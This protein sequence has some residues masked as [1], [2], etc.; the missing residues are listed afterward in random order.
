MYYVEYV[1]RLSKKCFSEHPMHTADNEYLRYIFLDGGRPMLQEQFLSTMMLAKDQ[2]AGAVPLSRTLCIIYKEEELMKLNECKL[3]DAGK[4][5]PGASRVCPL[6]QVETVVLCSTTSQDHFGGRK[7]KHFIGST[8]GTA[9]TEVPVLEWASRWQVPLDTKLAML[10]GGSARATTAV[11]HHHS[12]HP[13]VWEE[14]AHRTKACLVIDLT[15]RDEVLGLVC[16]EAGIPYVAVVHSRL[17]ANELQQQLVEQV[18]EA[19]KRPSSSLHKQKLAQKL[20]PRDC[21]KSK[22]KAKARVR[23]SGKAKAKVK[24]AAQDRAGP[25]LTQDTEGNAAKEQVATAVAVVP[26]LPPA[27]TAAKAKTKATSK[28]T[29]KRKRAQA[30]K[31]ESSESGTDS[32]PQD[33]GEDSED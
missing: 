28:A 8:S 27:A 12:S 13:H 18:I 29:A 20:E 2:H 30:E 9:I 24:A 6:E 32:E 10:A 1:L 26:V 7:N 17:H 14:L 16:M 5:N 33:S 3:E 23:G 15:A 22:A 19:F 31:S 25:N 4:M 11:V 21:P